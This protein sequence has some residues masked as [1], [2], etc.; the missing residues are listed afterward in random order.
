MLGVDVPLS[1]QSSYSGNTSM[2][3]FLKDAFEESDLMVNRAGFRD[4]VGNDEIVFESYGIPMP[5]LVRFPYAEYH[6]DKDNIDII[7]ETRL[8]EAKNV[9]LKMVECIERDF[10]I[11]KKFKGVVCLS[12]PDYNLYVEP[13]QPAFN[14][15]HKREFRKLME[16]MSLMPK[17]NF[18]S[19]ICRKFH[20]DKSEVNNYL[21]KWAELDLIEII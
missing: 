6:C 21:Q 15:V 14:N 18:L 9:L 4:L 16:Y 1:V 3:Q 7:R 11:R 20:L 12:N 8:S 10:Y 17:G 13:G 19:S 2:D 5:S